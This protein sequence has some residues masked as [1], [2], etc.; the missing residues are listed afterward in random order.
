MN[1][2][3]SFPMFRPRALLA[4]GASAF[5][6][7][8]ALPAFAQQTA[9]IAVGETFTTM[10]PY[11]SNDTVSQAAAKSFYE[12]LFGFDKD[13]K[14]V[15]VLATGYTASPDAKIY[16]VK[17]RQGVKFQDGTDFNA[18]AV[19]VV[20]DRVTDPA[21][22]LKRYNLFRVI[23]KTEVVD[24][25]TV[26]FTLREPFSA[27]INTLAH[28]SAVMI[29][30]A[31]LKKWGR[32]IGLHPVGTGP[33]EFV[34]W[35]QTDDMKVKKYAGYWKKGYPKID[36][37]DWKPVIDNNTR[38]ALMKAGQADLAF[39]IPYEQ[40]A[41][42]KTN[43]KLDVVERPSIVVRYISLN[44]LQKP[45]DNPKVRQALNYAINKEALA[46]VAFSG[47]AMP[48]PGVVPPGV[49]YATKTG[50]WPYDPAKARA[51]L[52]EAGYPNGFESTLWS[53]YNNTT[54]QKVIQFVQQQLAQVGVKVQVQALESGERV[55]KVE[56][57]QDP[58]S[59]PVRMFYIGWSSS[60]G[61]ANWALTP[62]LA[63]ASKPPKLFNTAYYQ[64][65][66][67]DE[68]LEKALSTTDRA[69]KAE[70]YAGVQKQIWADAPWIFLV[71]EKIVYARSK[72]LQGMYVMPD[73]SF[74]FDEISL[75]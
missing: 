37:I 14:L 74:N 1:K 12:G 39:R 55:S 68:G 22:K 47:F 70:Y 43:P 7:A 3:L 17:L 58:A 75:K 36:M 48:A 61:E 26:R 71:Q 31:A 73:G 10:D 72:R 33:F 11:D 25:Y 64:N 53:G 54:S 13:M 56:S 8:V 42:L 63:S 65:G 62:L 5:A 51:L 38:A 52:K 67:V 9:V 40:V 16:T 18:D 34:E 4:T 32:E 27:F 19:K 59:A 41:D 60:T 57:A 66:L 45:F 2:S 29:S 49:E 35:K 21:N 6:L 20:F 15:D 69:K 50:P 28:P 23:E 44:T 24:P 30:P 46:K